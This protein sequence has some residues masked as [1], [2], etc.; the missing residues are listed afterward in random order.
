V[1]PP[2]RSHGGVEGGVAV[3]VGGVTA[4]ARAGGS[5][6]TPRISF[7]PTVDRMSSRC[8]TTT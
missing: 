2:T 7:G 5:T 4:V 6:G 8:P 1:H 3:G